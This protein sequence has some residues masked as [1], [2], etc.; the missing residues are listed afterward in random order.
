MREN[1]SENVRDLN[2]VSWKF[3]KTYLDQIH[4]KR[5][6]NPCYSH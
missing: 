4:R 5:T 2:L 6:S 1:W 3:L